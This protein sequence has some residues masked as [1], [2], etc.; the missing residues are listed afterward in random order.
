MLNK[1][2]RHLEKTTWNVFETREVMLSSL[3][4]SV[5][6]SSLVSSR[7]PLNIWIFMFFTGLTWRILHFRATGWP[8]L[9]LDGDVL[10]LIFCGGTGRHMYQIKQVFIAKKYQLNCKNGVLW[11]I[12]TWWDL[13][14]PVRVNCWKVMFMPY[15]NNLNNNHQY[16]YHKCIYIV[17][18][19]KKKLL[20][21]YC[22][23]ETCI[24]MNVVSIPIVIFHFAPEH[25][26][27]QYWC[28]LQPDSITL[29]WKTWLR[30][31]LVTVTLAAANLS[32]EGP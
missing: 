8:A 5:N 20:T 6:C 30:Q 2:Q 27:I 24:G 10:I 14:Q 17:L 11:S 18:N 7:D 29:K 12:V 19:T 1:Q 3:V 21:F 9:I 31:L 15:F 22:Q 25:S 26:I 13:S 23:A 16:H 28:I 32:W 4:S